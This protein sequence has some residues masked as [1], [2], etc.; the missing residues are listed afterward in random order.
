MTFT[1]C[2]GYELSNV[3]R[4]RLG[5]E[6]GITGE[7]SLKNR[8]QGKTLSNEPLLNAFPMLLYAL[9]CFMSSLEQEQE[10]MLALCI[11]GFCFAE[12]G[13]KGK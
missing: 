13:K 1:A 11:T 12:A 10:M 2:S 4:E 3:P 8:K 6:H 5:V 7:S 9:L